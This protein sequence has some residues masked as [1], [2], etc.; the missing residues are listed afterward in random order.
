MLG[1]LA[2]NAGLE[3]TPHLGPG[4]GLAALNQLCVPLLGL[5]IDMTKDQAREIYYGMPYDDWRAQ[6]QTEAD[7]AKKAAFAEAYRANVGGEPPTK[8]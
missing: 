6:N 5:G 1:V 8:G 3:V 7:A 4:D 2:A